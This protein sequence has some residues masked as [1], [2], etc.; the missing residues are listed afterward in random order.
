MRIRDW[1]SDV[2]S[3]DLKV[4]ET[5]SS[6]FITVPRSNTSAMAPPL[7][8]LRLAI[9]DSGD[10]KERLLCLSRGSARWSP[11]FRNETGNSVRE[12]M[13]TQ[14]L[15]DDAGK[16]FPCRLFDQPGGMI[17]GHEMGGRRGRGK[18]G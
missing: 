5:D 14:R 7:H 8:L 2:C 11:A 13:L 15:F 16:S 9:F 3:S 12:G 4:S 17:G 18:G 10:N 6:V 1:S